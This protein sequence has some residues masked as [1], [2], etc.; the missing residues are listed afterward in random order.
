MI[1]DIEPRHLDNQYKPVPPDQESYALYYEDHAVLLKKTDEG[2]TY[3]RFREIDRLN[4][5]IYEDYIYL[6]SVDDERYYLV[7]EINREPLS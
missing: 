7:K 4:E 5:E 1:Q 6:F 3:P 2:I